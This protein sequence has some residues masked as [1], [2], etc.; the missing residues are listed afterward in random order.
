MAAPFLFDGIRKVDVKVSE[1]LRE[2]W[3]QATGSSTMTKGSASAADAEAE[4]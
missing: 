2:I 3:R 4:R 1:Q